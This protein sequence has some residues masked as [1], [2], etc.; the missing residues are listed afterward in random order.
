[1]N[2]NTRELSLILGWAGALR[3]NTSDNSCKVMGMMVK[4]VEPAESD[5]AV[6]GSPTRAS[7]NAFRYP[8]ICL[9]GL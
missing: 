6:K 1:M 9:V 8:V 4:L 5:Q 7:Q 2:F 3:Q